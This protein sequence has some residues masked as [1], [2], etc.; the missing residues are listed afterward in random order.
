[1]STNSGPKTSRR[2]FLRQTGL[3]TFFWGAG[4]IPQ[5]AAQAGKGRL[6]S[7]GKK[8]IVIG[9]DGMDPLLTERMMDA[10]ELPAFARLREQGGYRRLETSDPPQSPVAWASFINGSGPGS[11]GI[12]DFIHRDPSRQCFP[13]FSAAETTVGS[14][15]LDVGE[16]R[17]PLNFWPFNHTPPR[18]LLKRGG[19]PFWHYLEE[20]GI[21][22]VFYNLPAN[23]PPSPSLNGRYKCLA[24]MGTPDLLGTYGTYQHFAEDGPLRPQEE[25]GGRRSMLFFE[26]ETARAKLTGPV[27]AFLKDP[28]PVTVDFQI[29]R[30][31]KADAAVI[32]LQ[33]QVILLKKGQWSPWRRMDFALSMP[34]PDKHIRGICRFFLQEV[35]PNFRL[36]V[37][38]VNADPSDPGI[39]LT[40]P[41]D[42][43][44][45]IAQELGL[46]YT[47]GFQED[48][49]ALSNGVFTEE[50]FA[51]Q[52]EQVLQERLNLLEYAKRHYEDGLLFFYFSS[53]DLQSHMFWW[54]SDEMHPVRSKAR[55]QKGFGRVRELYTRMDHV[56]GEI[57]DAYGPETAV[58]VLSDHGFSN[59]GRQF[60]LNTWLR[61][62]G[63]LYPANAASLLQDVDWSRTRA[64]GLG[65][66]GLYLNLKGRERDGIITQEH[67]ETILQ[68]L[69]D[70]LE[71]VRDENGRAVIRK[72]RRSDQIYTGS[73][74][75]PAPDL[76]VGYS[77]GYRA[78]WATCLGDIESA[79]LSDNDSA[80]S[81]DHCCD[82]SEVPGVLFANRPI[83]MPHPSLVDLAPSIL[84]QFGL[85]APSTM[86]G[87]N[88][89]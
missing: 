64:Y 30:D 83:Q 31:I 19:T 8:V 12:F 23:Y 48:H 46:F 67:K 29:H 43:S 78:S 42:F 80:W 57:L 11:H 28:V 89:L 65:I 40:E 37:T 50:E 88:I 87:S 9:I 32:E 70:R 56:V 47:T 62:N 22:S 25:P 34:G 73:E 44:R 3:T 86:S 7:S 49:K 10:G 85:P 33:D 21:S 36:Y 76:I 52:A 55:A 63:Y 53:T 84:A 72:V 51:A 26:N 77:R 38:P 60:N 79:V 4:L 41:R 74:T 16:Y 24:G 59:F 6:A 68:E 45:Q 1:M 27:N 69:I 14:G 61:E 13:F 71:A 81:A 20:A 5:S 82:S 58:F 75:G 54:D 2:T 15:A 17:V 66:N 18:T 35:Y 39:G